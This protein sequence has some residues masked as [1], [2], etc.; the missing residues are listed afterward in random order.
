MCD[1]KYMIEYIETVNFE[2]VY[3]D[4]KLDTQLTIGKIKSWIYVINSNIVIW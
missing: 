3:M 4:G 1:L 2:F